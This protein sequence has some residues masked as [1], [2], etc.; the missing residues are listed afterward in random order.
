MTQV[1][2]NAHRVEVIDAPASGGSLAD[3]VAS[4]SSG[5]WATWDGGFLPASV[6]NIYSDDPSTSNGTRTNWD[7]IRGKFLYMGQ[8]H[9]NHYQTT[10][11]ELTTGATPTWANNLAVPFAGSV[12]N[13]GH[14]FSGQCANPANGD[15]YYSQYSGPHYFRAGGA[16]SWSFVGN[17]SNGRHGQLD[18]SVF[19]PEYGSAGGVVV[20]GS[21][22]ISVLN[23]QSL[24]WTQHWAGFGAGGLVCGNTSNSVQGNAVYDVAAGAAFMI[25]DSAHV[26]KISSAGVCTQK[27]SAPVGATIQQSNNFGGSSGEAVDGYTSTYAPTNGVVRKPILFVPGGNMWEYTSGTDTW[28]Q[29]AATAPP[30]AVQNN[31]FFCGSC[32][33]YDCVLAW[34]QTGTGGDATCHVYKR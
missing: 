17:S 24:V 34:I 22:G 14:Q 15:L 30:T 16:N 25:D 12:A 5:T 31:A 20:A 2:S 4:M 3:L 11:M 21:Y 28:S 6:V 23:A 7:P 27:N 10:M 29:L 26:V 9:G 33:T 32:K 13:P 8:G 19:L 18:G 1:A